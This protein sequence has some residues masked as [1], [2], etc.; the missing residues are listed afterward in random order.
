MSVAWM[1]IIAV[2]VLAQKIL[3]PIRAID[4]PVALALVAIGVLIVVVP[5]SIPGLMPSM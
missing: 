3:P 1:A 2:L 5:T 4:V